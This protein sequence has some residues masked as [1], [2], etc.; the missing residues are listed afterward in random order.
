MRI[1]IFTLL[2]AA[3]SSNASADYFK[4]KINPQYLQFE[5]DL[6]IFFGFNNETVKDK[7]EYQKK[8]N[9]FAADF[10]IEFMD[11]LYFS[12]NYTDSKK[13]GLG[14]GSNDYLDKYWYNFVYRFA[15]YEFINFYAYYSNFNKELFIK[16]QADYTFRKQKYLLGAGFGAAHMRNFSSISFDFVENSGMYGIIYSGLGSFE[17]K[18]EFISTNPYYPTPDKPL[19][20]KAKND[21]GYVFYMDMGGIYLYKSFYLG[22]KF[23]VGGFFNGKV[24]KNGSELEGEVITGT[25]MFEFVTGYKITDYWD[26]SLDYKLIEENNRNEGE[27]RDGSHF[28]V[29]YLKFNSKILLDF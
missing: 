7:Y 13:W 18:L 23:E 19:T 8:I 17:N 15:S 27:V 3:F 6:G 22:G 1:L 26:I 20:L 11:M 28:T 2:L 29:Y 16:D 4:I 24:T 14:K 12:L 9:S 25:L 10:S 21:L 5:E